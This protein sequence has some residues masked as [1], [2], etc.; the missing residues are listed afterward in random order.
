M[1]PNPASSTAQ[2]QGFEGNQ[3]S[4]HD[5]KIQQRVSDFMEIVNGLIPSR[6]GKLTCLKYLL[7]NNAKVLSNT[8]SAEEFNGKF[9]QFRN[10]LEIAIG[11]SKKESNRQEFLSALKTALAKKGFEDKY[12]SYVTAS[13]ELSGNELLSWIREKQNEI[14]PPRVKNRSHSQ[15]VLPAQ[16]DTVITTQTTTTTSTQPMFTTQAPMVM[17]YPAQ[18]TSQTGFPPMMSAY[19]Q[20]TTF[21]P[22]G[23]YF[24]TVMPMQAMPNP[25]PS[26]AQQ[27]QVAPMPYP[28][29]SMPTGMMG[30]S[31]VPFP[32][33]VTQPGFTPAN[34]IPAQQS[35]IPQPYPQTM[36]QS[37]GIPQAYPQ[38]ILQPMVP[39][40]GSTMTAQIPLAQP[41]PAPLPAQVTGWPSPTA[42]ISPQS[43]S[44]EK[45]NVNAQLSRETQKYLDS[46]FMLFTEAK[47]NRKGTITVIKYLVN[48]ET[49][50]PAQSPDGQRFNDKFFRFTHSFQAIA[51]NVSANEY[52][53]WT[54]QVLR[55][56]A[57][58]QLDAAEMA[59]LTTRFI[60][61]E[62]RH[63]IVAWL[64]TLY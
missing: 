24:P 44:T 38:T 37:P 41:A 25:A 54:F 2:R 5:K 61:D 47:F 56:I 51:N 30:G 39:V 58:T 45:V 36:A 55:R 57:Y 3:L 8:K 21:V 23:G 15:P 40:Y 9:D 60:I 43:T 29:T 17:Q 7:D 14:A 20:G 19:P 46:A 48:A 10:E 52:G 53:N 62:P 63:D 1:R 34:N 64:N 28:P 32:S 6:T 42:T 31:Y 35:G 11:V 12:D 18:M 50:R 33:M 26:V 4:R 22:V 13:N 59:L 16:S 27:Q 49:P